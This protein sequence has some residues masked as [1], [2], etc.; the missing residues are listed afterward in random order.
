MYPWE[1]ITLIPETE[2]ATYRRREWVSIV[3]SVLP[4]VL[5][6][7]ES[8]SSLQAAIVSAGLIADAVVAEADKR[9]NPP[10]IVASAAEKS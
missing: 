4:D 7:P 8:K 9:F 10:P 3:N 2:R 5:A 1:K 6:G